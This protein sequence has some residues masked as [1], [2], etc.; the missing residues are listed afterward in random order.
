MRIGR[1]TSVL[2]V[3]F[4]VWTWILWPNFLKNIWKDDKSWND[5]P[6][7]FFLVHLVLTVVSFAAGNAIGWLG[8]KGLR[9]TR[10]GADAAASPTV[11]DEAPT[12]ADARV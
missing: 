8:V 3:T 6:T 5:G 7:A 10:R 1:K 12:P 9:A 2:L 4:G 11:R